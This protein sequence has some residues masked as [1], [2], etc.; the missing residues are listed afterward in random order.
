MEFLTGTGR[1][2]R[3]MCVRAWQRGVLDFSA[4]AD[5]PLRCSTGVVAEAPM[6]L[7]LALS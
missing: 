1:D 6:T 2:N 4:L 7:G 3:G 5:L